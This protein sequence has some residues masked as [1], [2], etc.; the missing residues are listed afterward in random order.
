MQSSINFVKYYL[1]DRPIDCYEKSKKNGNV[2]TFTIRNHGD[3]PPDGKGWILSE[4][5]K[6]GFETGVKLSDE[7]D[8]TWVSDCKE[9]VIRSTSPTIE[10][11]FD[12]PLSNSTKRQFILQRIGTE[13]YGTTRQDLA[14]FICQTYIEIYD[15]EEA[16]SS[17]IRDPNSKLMNRPSTNGPYG[18]WGHDLSDLTLQEMY[19]DED[20][21]VWKLIIDS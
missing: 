10:I 4:S 9:V 15:E 12:Y 7:K 8:G 11:E 14:T 18:I 17:P 3:A 20:E 5:N 19:Y 13:C 2:V 16:T 21:H 6:T 1:Y